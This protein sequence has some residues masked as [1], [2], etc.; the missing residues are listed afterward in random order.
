MT[1]ERYKRR[2]I[3]LSPFVDSELVAIAKK[4]NI[5]VNK[6]VSE[7]IAYHINELDKVNNIGNVATILNKLE[8]LQ[9]DMDDFKKKYHW[10]NALIKQ[11]FVN[12]GFRLNRNL[13]DDPIFN[14]FVNTRYKEKYETKYNS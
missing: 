6:L 4:N 1:D 5:T 14:E 12:S 9:N 8:S 11:I 2:T 10:M 3:R 7:L 13:K